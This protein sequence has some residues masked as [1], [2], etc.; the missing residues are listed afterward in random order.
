M[1]K[2]VTTLRMLAMD[3]INA[4]NSGHPGVVLGFAPIAYTLWH[5]FLKITPK[6][7]N[8]FDR[9][10]FVLASGHASSMLYALLHLTGYK[11]TMDDLKN[12]RRLGSKTPGH[13]E[14]RHTEGLDSTSGPL[15]QGIAMAC[16]MAMAETMLAARFNKEDLKLVDHYTFVE[17]GDGDLQEGVTLEALS[18]IG[19]LKLN[20]LIILFDSNRIQLDGPVS[21]AGGFKN[22]KKYFESLGFNYLEVKNPEDGAEVK[23]MIAKAKKSSLPTIIEC[24]TTIGY[25][26]PLH[27]SCKSHGAPLGAENTAKL[28]EFLNYTNE[29]F[30]VD[31]DVYEDYRTPMKK[32]TSKYNKWNRT[33]KEYKKLY[34]EDYKVFEKVLNDDY[35]LTDDVFEGFEYKTEATRKTIG[36]IV[37]KISS[38]YPTFIAGSADLTASTNVKGLDGDYTEENRLGRNVNYGVREHAMGAIANGLTLS[39]VRNM[40]G[41]FFVFSDYMKPAIRMAA[42]MGIPSVFVFTHDS[43]AV[44]EDG[45]THEPIEQLAGLRAIPNLNVL[46]PA[47]PAET[48]AAIKYA[49]ASTK[50]P[51][52]LC[53]TRQ[54]LPLL[55]EVKVKEFAKGAIIRKPIKNADI[56]LVATGS[57]VSLAIKASEVLEAEGVKAQVTEIT[58]TNLYDKLDDTE[59]AKY[60]N[61]N[62][63]SMFIEMASPFGLTGYASNTY[64]INKFGASA[65]VKDIIPAYGFTA[66]KVA[67]AAKA[68]VK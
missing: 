63:P 7:P 52:V 35:S 55:E 23:K 12:F 25:G 4:A 59:K 36:K 49:F 31:E 20:K 8:W 26:S 50:T 9:D 61:P 68:L 67:E 47:D 15:G 22:A 53:L 45:P 11:V 32:N 66:E 10:R 62:K 33:L 41:A 19:H 60:V 17:C 6:N 29:P 65:N 14:Y 44:G 46:R 13:P 58:A 2:S 42:L 28:K 27:D 34:P 48:V 5:D 51:T 16:G 54:D 30:T 43:I 56:T 40:T 37:G 1:N 18:L 3:E 21:N 39:H 24:H 57:E 64:A 38:A